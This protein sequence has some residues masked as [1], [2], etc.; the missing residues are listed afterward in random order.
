MNDVKIFLVIG[1]IYFYLIF[2]VKKRVLLRLG[3]KLFISLKKLFWFLRPN[4][5]VI[6]FSTSSMPGYGTRNTF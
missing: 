5:D 1:P 2:E 6:K 3:K 4:Q